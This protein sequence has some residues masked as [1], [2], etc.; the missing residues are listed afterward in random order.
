MVELALRTALAVSAQNEFDRESHQ[1]TRA[2]LPACE[3][4]RWLRGR[5]FGCPPARKVHLPKSHVCGRRAQG[6]HEG[7]FQ[8][9]DERVV[10]GP[11]RDDFRD[12]I[13]GFEFGIEDGTKLGREIGDGIFG[14][15]T[16]GPNLSLLSFRTILRRGYFPGILM[17]KLRPSVSS[18]S[19]AERANLRNALAVLTSSTD[20][21]S[22]YV[23]RITRDQR[24]AQ[25]AAL[26]SSAAEVQRGVEKML[27]GVE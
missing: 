8:N 24:D 2:C 7:P 20:L 6:S 21:L 26:M 14:E 4:V 25:F 18:I 19:T 12:H 16:H 1:D 13:P 22:K 10:Q 5:I 3:C 23:D 27:E 17:K 11:S 9:H 15:H